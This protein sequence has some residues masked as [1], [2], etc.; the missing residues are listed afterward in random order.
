V[1]I[2]ERL[3]TR[4]PY[5]D[6]VSYKNASRLLIDKVTAGPKTRVG[7]RIGKLSDEDLAR[8]NRG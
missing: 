4:V 3:G 2:R 7:K 6:G 5:D 8:L 1:K